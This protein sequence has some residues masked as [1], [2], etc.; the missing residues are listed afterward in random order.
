MSWSLHKN[1]EKVYLYQNGRQ[2][3]NTKGEERGCVTHIGVAFL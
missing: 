1:E 2:C 3:L